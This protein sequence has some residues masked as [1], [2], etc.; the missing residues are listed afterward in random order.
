MYLYVPLADCK[1]ETV[2]A[3]IVRM[4]DGKI[5]QLPSAFQPMFNEVGKLWFIKN[6]YALDAAY[7]IHITK[8]EQKA[9]GTIFEDAGH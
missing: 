9:V 1:P 2:I 5:E 8:R 4:T 6:N 7:L 3:H